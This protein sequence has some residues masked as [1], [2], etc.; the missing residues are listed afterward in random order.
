MVKPCFS[1]W[2][3]VCQVEGSGEHPPLNTSEP[4][5]LG[6]VPGIPGAIKLPG[7]SCTFLRLG[8]LY[9]IQMKSSPISLEGADV[10]DSLGSGPRTTINS[11]YQHGNEMKSFPS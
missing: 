9:N 1:S 6:T 2:A 4:M 7:P 10:K 5:S 8:K 3:F 11:I